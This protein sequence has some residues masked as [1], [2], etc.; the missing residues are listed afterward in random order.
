MYLY[1]RPLRLATIAPLTSSA[2]PVCQPN[3]PARIAAA[4][5]SP[6]TGALIVNSTNES[7]K[8]STETTL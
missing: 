1:A 6:D 4:P 2:P 8:R 7:A 3:G 5:I